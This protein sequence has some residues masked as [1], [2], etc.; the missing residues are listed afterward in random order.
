MSLRARLLLALAAVSLVGLIVA[1]VVT[2]SSLRSFLL[3]RVDQQLASTTIPALFG[4]T[5]SGSGTT[6]NQPPPAVARAAAGVSL[7]VR[8]SDDQ[9]RVQL[10]AVEPGG[11]QYSPQLPSHISLSSSSEGQPAAVYF[12]VP[13]TTSGGPEFRVRASETPEGGLLIVGLPLDST[14][15]TLNRLV[16]IELAVTGGALIIAMG[17]G[18]WLV[19]VGLRPLEGV[20]RTADAIAAGQLDRRVPGD[21]ARTEVG[22]LARAL[23]VMLGRIQ[24]AFMERDATARRLAASEERMRRFVADASHELRTPLAAVSAYSEL[25]SRGAE[26]NP[27]DLERV[28]RGIRIESD[29]MT[30]LVEDL[31]LLARLDEGRPLEHAPVELVSLT[32]EAIHSATA[33]GPE[34]PITLRAERP[35]EVIGDGRRLRQVLDNLLTNVRAHTPPGTPAT[36]QVSAVGDR[37][38]VEVA[39]RGPGLGREQAERVFERFYRAD[40]SRSR[41]SGGAGLGLSIVAAIVASHGGEASVR[42]NPEGGTIFAVWLPLG[43]LPEPPHPTDQAREP[44]NGEMEPKRFAL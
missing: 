32:A 5:G 34:W 1:D 6:S 33:V 3:D 17:L 31:M 4:P 22:R 37:A 23:N 44:Q 15:A 14:Y 20:E 38:L 18:W 35:V 41:S 36:V 10:P 43:A 9:V 30:V 28:M 13:S 21:D 24:S 11:K 42:P 2:Y 40:A 27:A 16:L 19:R 26:H 12:D 25:F 29:R 7:E 39:D 8:A